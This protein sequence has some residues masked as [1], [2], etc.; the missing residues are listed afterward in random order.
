MTAPF[1]MAVKAADGTRS[2]GACTEAQVARSLATASSRGYT[3]EILPDGGFNVLRE[4]PGKG[5]H[6][7]KVTPVRKVRKLT[8]T[9][10]SDLALIGTRRAAE[11]VPA[12]GRINAGY[13]SSIPP[14]AS[15]DLMGQGLVTLAGNTV[16]VS[17]SARIAM[18]HQDSG[19]APWSY[20]PTALELL[21]LVLAA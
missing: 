2:E 14:A 18:L 6:V 1:R 16:T 13:F 7:V 17:L 4:I 12:T 8:R 11:F 20:K 10:R 9:V 3:V 15:A 5:C 19:H 21:R